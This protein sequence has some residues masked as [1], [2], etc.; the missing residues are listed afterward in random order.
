MK[1]AAP[2]IASL[3]AVPRRVWGGTALQVL[4]R[5]WTTGCTI[6]Y[7]W[8]AAGAQSLP[9]F[10]RFTFYLAAFAWLD[11]FTNMG[12][13]Q[14]AVQLTAND[15]G[16][17][18]AVLR[19]ARKVR[20]GAGLLGAA[21]VGGSAFLLGEPGAGWILVATLYPLTHTLELSATVYRNRIAWSVPVAT[22]A[23]GAGISLAL[24]GVLAARAETR[25]AVYLV[26]VAC[27]SAAANLLLHLFAR[28]HLPRAAGAPEP[29]AGFLRAAIPLGLSGLCAQTYFYVDNLFVRALLG[30]E[31][32][33]RY[34]VAVRVLSAAIM[35]ALYSTM[36][37]LPWFTRRH[38][39]GELGSAVSRLA[40]PLFALAGLGCGVLWPWTETLLELFQPGFGLAGGALRWLLLATLAIYV[41]AVLMTAVVA[42]GNT[43]AMFWIALLGLLVNL[44]LNAVLVVPMGIDGAAA[45]TLATEVTVALGALVALRRAGVHLGRG[46]PS[47]AWLGGP[48]GFAL[49]AG[50]SGWIASF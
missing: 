49:G 46:A 39:E 22:R 43:R 44:A 26:A 36:S 24:V 23:I 35:L 5:F 45:A 42:T 10:G 19:T 33:G 13:G 2:P 9:D 12:T 15:P 40:T 47:W 7:L 16:R 8:L 27:G 17:T 37:A 11:G 1:N 28:A 32:L 50:A 14:V 4:G 34:N 48:L 25:P 41:G 31:P 21:L 30:A 3:D 6:T 38:Q 20:F 18:S 29:L